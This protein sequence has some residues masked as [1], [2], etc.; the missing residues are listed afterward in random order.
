MKL[1]ERVRAFFTPAYEVREEALGG[2][3]CFCVYRRQ[4]GRVVFLERWGTLE[5]VARRVAELRGDTG[6]EV[7]ADRLQAALAGKPDPASQ[8]SD[9][10]PSRRLYLGNRAREVLEN[11]CWAWAFNTTRQEII[12]SWQATNAK[13]PQSRESMWLALKLLDRLQGALQ[14]RLETGQ[15]AALELEHLARVEAQAKE[16]LA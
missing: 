10:S 16:W 2:S 8:E 13:D 1:I 5:S 12:E 6:A 9:L 15:L 7:P 3:P 14:S 4:F 11:E